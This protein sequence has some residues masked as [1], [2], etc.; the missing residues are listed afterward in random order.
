MDCTTV[1]SKNLAERYLVG[2]LEP[3][4]RDQFERHYFECDV[5]YGDLQRL[6]A[7]REALRT[8]EIQGPVS[9]RT[10]RDRSRPWVWTTVAT[11]AASTAIV[12]ILVSQHAREDRVPVAAVGSPANQ[13]PV[14]A[15]GAGPAPP[16][17]ALEAP[18]AADRGSPPVESRPDR[19]QLLSRLARV[20][21]PTFS[22]LVLRGSQ[23]EASRLFRDGMQDYMRGNYAAA[24]PAF[25]RASAADDSRPNIVFYLAASQLMNGDLL[26]AE[27]SFRGIIGRGETPFLS[28]SHFYLAKAH[29]ARGDVVAARVELE[30]TA[31]LPG[32]QQQEA[33]RLLTELE[34][35][36][37]E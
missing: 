18:A 28:E 20:E 30:Q 16:D 27:S 6:T 3:G 37:A 19:A 12:A 33:A 17:E 13:E 34:Q 35:L 9:V 7:I 14:A 8:M 22:P 1:S 32:A 25:A 2:D 26:A 29:L 15:P 36:S 4:L 31:T 10:T 24:I 21:P 23:D 5:C 11:L